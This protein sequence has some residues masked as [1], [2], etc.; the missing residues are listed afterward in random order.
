MGS[1][2]RVRHRGA[3]SSWLQLWSGLQQACVESV[4]SG[5]RAAELCARRREMQGEGQ[6][7]T[8]LHDQR[9]RG[10][11][12]GGLGK[13]A[14][15]SAVAGTAARRPWKLPGVGT[16]RVCSMES[17]RCFLKNLF[18]MCRSPTAQP[19]LHS[20]QSDSKLRMA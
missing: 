8:D 4:Q 9:R 19:V 14:V 13:S 10:A 2:H 6:A 15:S 5:S 16:F 1:Q 20:C 17:F 12:R 11:T 7:C 18:P 3:A